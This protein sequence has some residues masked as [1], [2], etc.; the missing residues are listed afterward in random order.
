MAARP[1]DR[2][3]EHLPAPIAEQLRQRAQRHD[4]TG[5]WPELDLAVLAEEAGAM[6][7]AVLREFGGED[8][9]ALALHLRYEA[10]AACSL[11]TALVLTQRDS[12]VGLLAASTNEELKRKLLPKL[13]AN[14]IFATVGIAQLTTSRQGGTPAVR[15]IADNGGWRIDGAIPWCTGAGKADYIV[16]GA[17]I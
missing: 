8:V 14:E 13:A 12:A 10:L 2:T 11:A 15:A 3:L 16:A 1:M 6:R 5:A 17:A 9:D 4:Q 7:W